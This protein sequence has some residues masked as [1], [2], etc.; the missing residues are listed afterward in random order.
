[1]A[2]AANA[3]F[4]ECNKVGDIKKAGEFSPAF[5]TRI[6]IKLPYIETRLKLVTFH[7]YNPASINRNRSTT[8]S[9]S[10]FPLQ[11]LCQLCLEHNQDVLDSLQIINLKFFG[12]A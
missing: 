10:F 1:M 7:P 12:F 3:K 4:D 11:L 6:I 2:G 8:W 5:L 9:S